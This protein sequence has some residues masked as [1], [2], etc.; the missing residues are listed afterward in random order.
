ME[1][2]K[3]GHLD[4]LF[5]PH[6]RVTSLAPVHYNAD[7]DECYGRRTLCH[8]VCV[9]TNGSYRCDCEDGYKLDSNERDCYSKSLRE[10]EREGGESPI[11]HFVKH[12]TAEPLN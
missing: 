11:N 10:E 3:S 1:T 7:V 2:L 9:N 5:C 4:T 8:Q 12:Y 6:T